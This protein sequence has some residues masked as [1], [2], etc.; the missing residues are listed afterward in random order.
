MSWI[1]I[2]T[3]QSRWEA[4]LV[5]QILAAQGIPSRILDLGA[6]TYLC[7]GGPTVVQVLPQHHWTALLLLSTPEELAPEDASSD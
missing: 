3:T 6:P 7:L 4:E 1:T 5:Q 2:R